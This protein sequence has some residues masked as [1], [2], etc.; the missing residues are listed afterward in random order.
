MVVGSSMSIREDSEAFVWCGNPVLEEVEEIG[1]MYDLEYILIKTGA[2]ET[3]LMGSMWV[4]NEATGIS[5]DGSR[6]VGWGINPD[7]P[8]GAEKNGDATLLADTPFHG[9]QGFPVLV[10]GPPAAGDDAVVAPRLRAPG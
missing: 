7:G 6:I 8:E 5:D 4:L 10:P 3:S 9:E 1:Y 2:A